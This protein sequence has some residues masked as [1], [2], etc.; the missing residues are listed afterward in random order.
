MNVKDKDKET[1]DH[2]EKNTDSKT[3]RHYHYHRH[4]HTISTTKPRTNRNQYLCTKPSIYT[5]NP[6]HYHIPEEY[7]RLKRTMNNPNLHVPWR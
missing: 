6:R 4:R 1:Q 7:P 2:I 3:D 5:P